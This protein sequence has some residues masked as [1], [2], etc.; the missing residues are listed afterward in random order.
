MRLLVIE[1]TTEIIDTIAQI[2][3][4]RWPEASVLSTRLGQTGVEL[5]KKENPN[6]IILDLGLP[7]IDGFQVLRQ[8]RRFSDVP[9]IILTVRG[10]DMDK[11]RGLDLGAVEYLVKPIPIRELAARVR[12][13]LRLK[14]RQ[15]EIF[16][17]YQHLSEL[18]LTDP[19]TGAYNRRAL[20]Q[21]LKARLAESTRYN[22]PVSCVMFDLDHFKQV[23][24]TY[25]H[26]TGDLVLREVS[27]LTLSLFR[28][29]DV[30]IR[31]GGEEFLVILFHTFKKG[32]LA[33][34]ERLRTQVASHAFTWEGEPFRITLSAGIATYP[35]DS[36]I[37]GIAPKCRDKITREVFDHSMV[38]MMETMIAVADRRLYAGKRAGRNQVIAT[39]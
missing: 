14:R 29:E 1:D 6:L 36:E 4:L 16:A 11:I 26:A 2:I 19:L 17:R 9:V 15:D 25:G 21:L 30:L 32:A 8:I 23:N 34:A 33:F 20:D 27:A 38:I 18:S 24:D 5:A 13:L 39:D 28:Q 10:D 31:Y 22:I 12:A 37:E 7:D 35:E 3:D